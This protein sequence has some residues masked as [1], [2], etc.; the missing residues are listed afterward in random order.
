MSGVHWCPTGTASSVIAGVGQLIPS[1]E[2]RGKIG[3]RHPKRL[4]VIQVRKGSRWVTFAKVKTTRR[5]T[6][7][8][9]KPLKA[10][11]HFKFRARTG[12]DRQHLAGLS[13][14]VRL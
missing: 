3:P 13:R 11:A 12:A 4:V 8:L 5:S 7:L 14:V 6:F 9:V 1:G 2:L 10:G